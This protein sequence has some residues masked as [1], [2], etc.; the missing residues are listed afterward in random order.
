MVFEATITNECFFGGLTI[1][2]NGFSMV[3]GLSTITF[4]GF[5]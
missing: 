1:V 5:Q 3:F 4:N 2:I